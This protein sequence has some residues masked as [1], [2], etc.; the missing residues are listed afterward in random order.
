M[1]RK[2]RSGKLKLLAVVIIVAAA[3]G[4]FLL[5]KNAVRHM[6]QPTAKQQAGYNTEDRHK[7]ERLIHEETKND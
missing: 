3:G 4:F 1:R 2:S 7:L 6:P 5:R